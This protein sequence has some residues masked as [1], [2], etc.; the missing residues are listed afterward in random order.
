MFVIIPVS[1]TWC[2]RRHLA[3]VFPNKSKYFIKKGK[4]TW[5]K[6]TYSRTFVCWTR[7]H[8]KHRLTMCQCVDWQQEKNFPMNRIF[9]PLIRI[10][11][12]ENVFL[13]TFITLSF[14]YTLPMMYKKQSNHRSFWLFGTRDQCCRR[15]FFHRL[16]WGWFGDDSRTLPLL[17]TLFLLLWH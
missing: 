8:S 14:F 13:S 7:I 1:E 17:Y 15:L 5:L 3:L 4:E 16:G 2:I 10:L 9:S 11:S 6:G 12:G